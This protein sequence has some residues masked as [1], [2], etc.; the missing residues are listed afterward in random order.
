MKYS[1]ITNEP[2][3]V[4]LIGI[5]KRAN[6]SQKIVKVSSFKDIKVSY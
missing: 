4:S 2:E 6:I 3:S 5:E 1:F